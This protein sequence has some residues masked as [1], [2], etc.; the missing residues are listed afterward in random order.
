MTVIYVAEGH[1]WMNK[2]QSSGHSERF[3]RRRSNVMIDDECAIVCRILLSVARGSRW[4]DPAES[5][6]SIS[7]FAADLVC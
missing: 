4:P 6:D 3:P 5:T 7:M 2:R 1:K